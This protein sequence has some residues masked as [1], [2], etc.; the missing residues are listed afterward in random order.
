[1]AEIFSD[2]TALNQ[3]M[4]ETVMRSYSTAMVNHRVKQ[5]MLLDILTKGRTSAPSQKK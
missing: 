5:V 4:T 1:M 2:L 3:L